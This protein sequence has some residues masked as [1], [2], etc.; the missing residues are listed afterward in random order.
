MSDEA[1]LYETYDLRDHVIRNCEWTNNGQAKHRTKQQ[2]LATVLTEEIMAQL[3]EFLGNALGRVTIGGELSHSKEYGCSAKSFVSMS[4]TCDN[5]LETCQAVHDVVQPTV[6]ALLNEDLSMMKEDRDHH[7]Q[8]EQAAAPAAPEG[9]FSPGPPQPKKIV[10]RT[11]T[12][13]PMAAAPAVNAVKK[14]PPK[15]SFRR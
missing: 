11:S 5:S 10:P 14:L 7:L 12:P 13:N 3:D 4:I 15:P 1:V 8:G 2:E 9:R 6:R